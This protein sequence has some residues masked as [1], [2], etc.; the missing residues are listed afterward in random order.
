MLELSRPQCAVL[1]FAGGLLV[2]VL[3]FSVA[4]LV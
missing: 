1:G 3:A 4:V 2:A